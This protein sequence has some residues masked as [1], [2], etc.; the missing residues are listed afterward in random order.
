MDEEDRPIGAVLAGGAGRRLGGGKAVVGLRGRPL[1]RYPLAAVQAV[2]DEV[3]VVAKGE[4][5]LPALPAEVALWVEPDAPR[6]PLA[7]IV[8][9]LERAG[10]RPVL[11]C[12]GDLPLVTPELLG[13]VLAVDDGA[14]P[15]VVPVLHGRLQPLV[16]LYRPAA[17]PPLAAALAASPLPALRDAVAALGPLSLPCADERPFLNVNV[18]E[19]LL[20]AAALLDRPAG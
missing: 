1:L 9:A 19:D 16:A 20:A 11:V 6:H 3:A 17:L 2:L 5:E 12:A 13:A 8:H 7:G 14:A 10:G 4:T 18:P 15:A